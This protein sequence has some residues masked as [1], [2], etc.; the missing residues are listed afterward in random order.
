MRPRLTSDE[1]LL[2]AALQAFA[3][4][5]YEGASIRALC[6]LLDVSH[7][8]L[9]QRFGSKEALWY[10]A[11][12]HGFK[13]LVGELLTAVTSA[14]GDPID[15]LR[16]TMVRYLET[17]RANPG[18]TQIINQ[19][20]TR[21]GPRYE[22]MYTRYIEPI[23][24]L[25]LRPLRQ[26]QADGVIRPGPVSTIFYYLTTFGL[27]LMNSHPEGFRSIGDPTVDLEEATALAI[28]I[29]LDGLRAP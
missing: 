17:T 7:N 24:E 14:G 9:N 29:V 11:V 20:S 27:G 22:Y 26:M 12:D 21:P 19:E 25:G 10:A 1:V 2:D 3:E 15:Q 16:A 28:D 23:N 13:T 5:G 8:T 18:L 4:L 6:R